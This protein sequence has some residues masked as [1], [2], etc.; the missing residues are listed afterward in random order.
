MISDFREDFG[1]PDLPFVAGQLSQ[2]DKNDDFNSNLAAIKDVSN[3]SYATSENLE[4]SDET[5]FITDGLREY[6]D[7]YALEMLNLL[8]I[9]ATEDD[10]PVHPEEDNQAF[11]PDL[12]KTYYIQS[13]NGNLLAGFSDETSK[14]A[15]SVS[16]TTTGASVEW[17]FIAEEDGNG[18]HIDL[19]LSLI[20]I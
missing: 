10:L 1:D 2:E 5:H 20:H 16:G 9:N 14:G 11:I 12:T 7:R 19:V 18:Y 4:T 3:V 17:K 8:G 6:G 13:L 15:A